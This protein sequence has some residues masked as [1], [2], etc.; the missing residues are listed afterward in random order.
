M[1]GVTEEAVDVI[2]SLNQSVAV[3]THSLIGRLTM[4]LVL[5]RALQKVW[6]HKLVTKVVMV[7]TRAG[8]AFHRK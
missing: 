5:K 2:E 1:G 3:R 8:R 7:A 6:A 4:S